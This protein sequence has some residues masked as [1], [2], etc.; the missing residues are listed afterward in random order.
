MA[1]MNWAVIMAGGVGERFWPLS[2]RK[3]PKQLLPIVGKQTMIQQTVARLTGVVPPSRILVI[4]NAEQAPLVRKQLPRVKHV[5]AEPVG[6]NT[7]PCVAYA[8][9]I[10]RERDPDAVMAVVPADSYIPD[11]ARYRRVVGESLQ[12]AG[13]EN[14]LI[15]I[16]IKPATPHTGYGYIQL[17]ERLND[18]F[19]KARRFVEKPDR[20]TA[21]QFL[22]SGEYRWNA[23]MFV[24]SL[25]AIGEAFQKYRPDMWLDARSLKRRYAKLERSPSTTP[26][27]R[28][29]T[30]SSSPTAILRGMT[31]AIGPQWNVTASVP[32]RSLCR[33]ILPAAWLRAN[34]VTR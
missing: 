25:R 3:R 22:A 20:A 30:T 34:P 6:R 7:A 8:A 14:V 19:W 28:R 27:W 4:T 15:T 18:R 29:P 33:W 26:S 2:R 31:S 32:D 23:G 24:W 10:I 12:F 13:H 21:E 1:K 5:V 9:A 11:T 16:G 17:G